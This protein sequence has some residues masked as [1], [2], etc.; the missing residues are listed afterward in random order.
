MMLG[1]IRDYLRQRGQVTV[2][3]VALHFDI[4]PDTARFALNYWQQRGRASTQSAACGNGGCSSGQCSAGGSALLYRWQ[5]AE[6]PLRL[7]PRVPKPQ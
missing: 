7:F 4:A 5:P 3:D 1:D 2:Q 6:I